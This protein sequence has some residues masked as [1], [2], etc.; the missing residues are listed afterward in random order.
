MSPCILVRSFFDFA[1]QKAVAFPLSLALIL[2]SGALTNSFTTS[3]QTF[4][5]D[6]D[7]DHER[8][9]AVVLLQLTS[10]SQ[11]GER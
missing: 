10:S 8:R 6:R 11:I 3:K 7:R 4:L 5:H 2:I 1:F 9:A